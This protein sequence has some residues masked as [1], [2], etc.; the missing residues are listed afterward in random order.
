MRTTPPVSTAPPQSAAAAD[1]QPAGPAL[2]AR[3]L[4]RHFTRKH[5]VKNA[6]FNVPR[7]HIF[8][9]LGPNGA[10][11]TTV[12]R[13]VL[14]LLR[15]D[16]GE[17]RVLGLDPVRNPRAVRL[18]TGYVSQLHSLYGDLTVDENLR[19]FGRLYGLAGEEL[20]RRI[21]EEKE[22]FRLVEH[23][24]PA[25]GLGTG[26]QRRT[27][28][29]CALLH[30]PELLILDEPTSGMDSLGR[31]D[32]WTFLGGLTADGTTIVIT[33]H[34]LEE[35]E[36]CDD[37]ALMLDGEV[38]FQGSPTELK[39]RFAGPVLAVSC[40]PWEVGFAVLREAYGASLFGT[41]SHID[42]LVATRADVETLLAGRSVRLLG[43]EERPPSMED[44]FLRATMGK[45]SDEK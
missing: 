45:S 40:E 44:A 6:S 10:G 2:S 5:A 1:A 14:G 25:A 20:N 21:A 24:G 11:K 26:V 36:G 29:A 7:G 17:I 33:T 39:A 12:L 19:F 41:C 27:A 18:R 35:A 9:F 38:R 8:G 42:G 30:R 15:P 34:H 43:I 16:S 23:R 3:G 37:L 4:D 13:L 31:R 22:R 32:F 28:L